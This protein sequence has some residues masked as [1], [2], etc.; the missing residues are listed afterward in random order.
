MHGIELSVILL[1]LKYIILDQK[2]TEY[3]HKYPS[4]L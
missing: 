3:Y 2:V 1:M 4:S